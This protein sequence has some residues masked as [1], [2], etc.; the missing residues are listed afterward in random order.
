MV[1]GQLPC[2]VPLIL[3]TGTS[4]VMEDSSTLGLDL[5]L[6]PG[7]M[8]SLADDSTLFHTFDT[9]VC[10]T[11]HAYISLLAVIIF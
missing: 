6:R 5:F 11:A 8:N 3:F 4:F 7:I 2:W 10:D 9:L 1:T